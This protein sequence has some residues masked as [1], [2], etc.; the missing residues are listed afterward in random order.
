MNVYIIKPWITLNN[1]SYVQYQ[2]F[3][4]SPVIQYIYAY[5]KFSVVKDKYLVKYG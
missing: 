3:L 1:V 5:V 4:N 2:H